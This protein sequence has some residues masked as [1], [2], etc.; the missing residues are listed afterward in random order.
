MFKSKERISTARLLSDMI[1]ADN[2]IEESEIEMLNRFKS[3]YSID[4]QTH[5]LN[6]IFL[7]EQFLIQLNVLIKNYFFLYI[8]ISQGLRNIHFSKKTIYSQ[9]KC[10]FVAK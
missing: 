2:I 1:K 3:I 4:S 8:F 7:K 10:I 5:G 9:K 6:N